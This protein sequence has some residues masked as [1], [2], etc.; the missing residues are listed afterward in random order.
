MA[1]RLLPVLAEDPGQLVFGRFGQKRARE[2]SADDNL[3]VGTR[4]DLGRVAPFAEEAG[5]Q[6]PLS[7]AVG[8]ILEAGK[9]AAAME[10]ADVV[11]HL[12]A[13][14]GVGP[15]VEDPRA[16]CA[17]NVTGTLNALEAARAAAR[18][19]VDSLSRSTDAP[20]VCVLTVADGGQVVS[21]FERDARTLTR[22]TSRLPWCSSA[23]PVGANGA[24]ATP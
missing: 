24:R 11:V 21:G 15:S 20:R 7:L 9:M 16:D 19:I 4:E 2:R 22:S 23:G 13:N 14:T 12:A 10:G 6:V 8:D 1:A 3:S 17:A 5:W 18:E